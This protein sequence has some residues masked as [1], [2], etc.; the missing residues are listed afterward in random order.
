MQVPETHCCVPE[1][2]LPQGPHVVF[3]QTL[4]PQ[5]VVPVGQP[6]QLEA[7]QVCCAL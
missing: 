7:T 2:G 5:L 3:W 4:L 6:P 1:Q